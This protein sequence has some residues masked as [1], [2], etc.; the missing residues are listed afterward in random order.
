MT[1][2]CAA[3]RAAF[4]VPALLL[5]SVS[6][7]GCAYW[8]SDNVQNRAGIADAT[9][10]TAVTEDGTPYIAALRLTDGKEYGDVTL[11]IETNSGYKVRYSAGEV[12]AFQGQ[13]FR[14]DLEKRVAEAAGDAGPDIVESI[15]RAVLD[16]LKPGG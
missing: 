5:A 9:V 10:E 6:L 1:R 8:G 13:Q 14:A 2:I 15:T 12:G 16:L 11:E 4:F 3:L 7:G